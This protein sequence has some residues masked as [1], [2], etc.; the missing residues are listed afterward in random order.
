V[1]RFYDESAAARSQR[2]RAVTDT[3]T[4][5]DGHRLAVIGTG[6]MGREHLRVAHLLGRASVIGIYDASADSV[7]LAL[8]E[9]SHRSNLPLRV[10]DGPEA[11]FADDGID[12]IIISTPNYT[13]AKLV[14]AA[15]DSGKALLV[16]KP[17]ATTL[18]DA[19]DMAGKVREHPAPVQLGMQYRFKAQYVDL[20]HAVKRAGA[21]GRV[22]TIS[23]AE[24][25]PPFL[26]KV[27]Q[28]NKFNEYS[29]GTLVEKCCHYF[30]L[31]NAMAE[32]TPRTV[33]ASGGRA[34]NFVDF[35]HQG[36]ASDID[37]HAFVIID[38]DN[39]VRANFTLNMFCEELYEEMIVGG[40]RGRAVATE[41]ATF[42]RDE[43]SR[44]SLQVEVSGHPLYD[45]RTVGYPTHIENSGHYGATY[46]AHE[47]FMDQLERIQ[48]DGATARQGL[49]AMIVASAAQ[50]SLRSG[51]P[52]EIGE[53][54][55]R[56]GS[57]LAYVESL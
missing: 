20:F 9:H 26:D 17:M 1:S 5:V 56:A 14:A 7:A 35:E 24:Y 31:L 21:L 54:L 16:E 57:S 49:W 10:Y 55:L 44:A 53:Y 6:M 11:V 27:G 39:G 46:F 12:G 40:D 51:T 13:H 41:R 30:D 4:T 32:S 19:I 52:V 37:D 29:G 45:G 50:E 47:A 38:Y 8:E 3:P 42:K 22:R 36:L 15:L 2:T 33:Y 18:E 25:R 23:M 34:V 28:W 48:A 43:P